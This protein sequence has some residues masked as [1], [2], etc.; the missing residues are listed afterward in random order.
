MRRSRS[1]WFRADPD[2]GEDSK[3]VPRMPLEGISSNVF[4]KIGP[5]KDSLDQILVWFLGDVVRH[6]LSESTDGFPH[7]SK[8]VAGLIA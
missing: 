6:P 2:L 1:L 5:A 7:R 4:G 8:I 3:I